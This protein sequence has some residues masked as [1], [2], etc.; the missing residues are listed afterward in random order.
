M[1]T[2][3]PNPCAWPS[4]VCPCHHH[5]LGGHRSL[6]AVTAIRRG[7][8]AFPGWPGACVL[9]VGMV[10]PF[11]WG[12]LRPCPCA[13]YCVKGGT[14]PAGDVAWACGSNHTPCSSAAPSLQKA[15]Q[16][17]SR[18]PPHPLSPTQ[19]PH[20]DHPPEGAGPPTRPP[21]L[22][23]AADVGV[24]LV[25]LLLLNLNVADVTSSKSTRVSGAPSFQGRVSAGELHR[26]APL[27]A[28]EGAGA[29]GGCWRRPAQV[30]A[31]K[32]TKLQNSKS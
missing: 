1:G 20:S 30:S 19:P 28:E 26:P 27:V 4:G 16:G 9:S 3:L 17:G 11:L 23:S 22:Q 31:S 2:P 5:A 21:H 10:T 7:D 12:Q 24:L 8:L 32:T 25:S 29:S 18:Q 14:V 15:V 6:R 13:A